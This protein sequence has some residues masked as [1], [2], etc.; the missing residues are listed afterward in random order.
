MELGS[1]RVMGGKCWFREDLKSYDISKETIKGKEVGL[2]VVRSRCFSLWIRF[3]ERGLALLL[4]GVELCCGS[5]S[6]K[7]FSM[8]WKERG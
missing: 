1:P 2:L 3:G 5:S 6:R 4:E 7:S 8:E